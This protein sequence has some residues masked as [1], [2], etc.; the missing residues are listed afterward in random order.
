MS[1]SFTAEALANAAVCLKP[2]VERKLIGT[3]DS[4]SI[5]VRENDRRGGPC[6]ICLTYYRETCGT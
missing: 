1:A 3:T 6:I 5:A 4:E 2:E